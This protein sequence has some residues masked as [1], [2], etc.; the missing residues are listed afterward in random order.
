MNYNTQEIWE[1][2]SQRLLYFIKVRVNNENDAEDILQEVF[3][4]IHKNLDSLSNEAKLPAWIY[5]I[6]RN[7]IIDFY[8]RKHST[9]VSFQDNNEYLQNKESGKGIHDIKG[10]LNSFIKQL[11]NKYKSAVEL[12]DI[13]GLKQKEIAEIF[14][15]SIPGAKSRVQRGREMI[16]QHFIDCCKFTLDKKG[17]LIGGEWPNENCTTCETCTT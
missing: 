9:K 11:P 15:I 10:C 4:K 8:R 12:S 5:R 1:S 7:S 16:K 6:T 17:K 14:N 13:K 2:F 3:L